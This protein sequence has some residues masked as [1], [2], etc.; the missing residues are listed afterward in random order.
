MELFSNK[1][2]V[3]ST[4]YTLLN[5]HKWYESKWLLKELE[6][7]LTPQGPVVESWFSVNPGLKVNPL[8]YFVCLNATLSFTTC[9]KK[10]SID[11][12]KIYEKYFQIYEKVLGKFALNFELTQG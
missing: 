4:S 5:P 7:K 9:E 2:V 12:G 11:P 6:Y 10:T 1:K 8:F 3:S